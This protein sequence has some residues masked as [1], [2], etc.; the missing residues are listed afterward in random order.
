MGRLDGRVALVSGAAMGMGQAAALRLAT[1]GASIAIIDRADAAET[2]EKVKA[3]GSTAAG[4][5]ADVTDEDQVNNAVKQAG[6]HFGRIDIL[7]N[8][9]GKISPRIPW[10]EHTKAQV[11]EFIDIN[12]IGYFLMTKAAYEWLK[13]SETPRVINVA[14]RT[15]FLAGPGQMGYVA[16]KGA[17]VGMTRVLAREMGDDGITVNAVMPG[18]IATPGTRQYNG[19][20][21][22]DRTM[23]NQAIKKRG[24][25]EH[26]AALIAFLAS[27][28]AEI[29]TGQTIICDGGGFMH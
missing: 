8:N 22:F 13:K 5:I 9:A 2:I 12:Y 10:N 11:E 1:D 17:V 27:D 20:E 19:E 29:I 16:S 28:D 21:V 14:S 15:F 24:M 3:Q 23:A 26:L 18:Q 25:P 6:E 7:V 4:F